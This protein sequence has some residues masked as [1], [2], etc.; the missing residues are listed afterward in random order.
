[1][2]RGKKASLSL[3]NE[4]NSSGEQNEKLSS[5]KQITSLNGVKHIIVLHNIMNKK[6]LNFVDKEI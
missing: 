2:R 4:Q 5:E 1:M 3:I 6:E